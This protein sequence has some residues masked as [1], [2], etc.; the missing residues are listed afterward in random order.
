MP[1]SAAAA[2]GLTVPPLGINGINPSLSALTFVVEIATFP[3]P[4]NRYGQYL[5]DN[6][7]F[8]K[9]DHAY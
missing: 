9:F 7:I 2:F 3:K 4:Q 6:T 8:L 1:T 5:F